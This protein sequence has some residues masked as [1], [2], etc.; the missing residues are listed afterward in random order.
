MVPVRTVDAGPSE[1]AIPAGRP[2]RRRCTP[3]ASSTMSPLTDATK[4]TDVNDAAQQS[5]R[6]DMNGVRWRYSEIRKAQWGGEQLQLPSSA[7]LPTMPRGGTRGKHSVHGLLADLPVSGAAGRAGE[8]PAGRACGPTQAGTHAGESGQRRQQKLQPSP[9]ASSPSSKRTGTSP[10]SC[11]SCRPCRL[12]NGGTY[13]STRRP[14]CCGGSSRRCAGLRVSDPLSAD[15][16]E[17]AGRGSQ[18]ALIGAGRSSGSS[19]FMSS[20][21][22]WVAKF[23]PVYY[24][25]ARGRKPSAPDVAR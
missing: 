6:S 14:T 4:V 11:L 10:A 23:R 5:P 15:L 3:G 16:S 19:R 17:V 25:D 20:F 9:S 21:P 12:K 18:V 13:A 8:T 1:R 22:S 7:R 24:F 2:R